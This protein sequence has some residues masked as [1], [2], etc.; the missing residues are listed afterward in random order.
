MASVRIE[1]TEK[2][3]A[4]TNDDRLTFPP[5]FPFP[6]PLSSSSLSPSSPS[7]PSA[8]LVLAGGAEDVALAVVFAGGFALLAD[9][10]C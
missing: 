7:S 4:L 8:L 2:V 9:V 5:P 6:F 3:K 1:T 10:G